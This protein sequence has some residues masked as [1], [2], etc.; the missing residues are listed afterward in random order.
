MYILCWT[1]LPWISEY[2][3]RLWVQFGHVH[4]HCMCMCS[5]SKLVPKPHTGMY[6][7]TDSTSCVLWL[8]FTEI[9]TISFNTARLWSC[10]YCIALSKLVSATLWWLISFNAA[11]LWVQFGHGHTANWPCTS[12]YYYKQHCIIMVTFLPDYHQT[13]LTQFG[14]GHTCMSTLHVFTEQFNVL[15]LYIDFLIPRSSS[16]SPFSAEVHGP[17]TACTPP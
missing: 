5:L 12:M 8:I 1:L 13:L 3:H 7:A 11:R 17:Y 10:P 16:A 15:I 6:Y 4:V 2:Q 9:L 14:L